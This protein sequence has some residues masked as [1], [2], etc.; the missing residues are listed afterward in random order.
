MPNRKAIITQYQTP[1]DEHGERTDI[2]PRT[3]AK[4]I[5][6]FDKNGQQMTLEEFLQQKVEN[7]ESVR[8]EDIPYISRTKPDH[9]CLWAKVVDVSET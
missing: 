7:S 5:E 2:F 9:A 1:K 6:Y 4:A 3:V 8:S